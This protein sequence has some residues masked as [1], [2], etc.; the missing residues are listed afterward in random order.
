MEAGRTA[1]F[2]CLWCGRSWQARS[3]GDLEAW[4][5]LC[6]D[7]LGRAGENAFLR[8]RLK[9][10]LVERAAAAG[11]EAGEG[12]GAALSSHEGGGQEPGAHADEAAARTGA[13]GD[14]SAVLEDWYLRR[15]PFAGGPLQD[16]A[17]QA[18]LDAAGRWLEGLALGPRIVE[19]ADGT[20][21]WSPLLSSVAELWT[22]A[23]RPADLE[24]TRERLLAH[25]LRAHLHVRD[26]W[27]EPAPPA[28]PAD[29]LFA[30][31][32][33]GRL[34]A[35]R[36]PAFAALARRWLRADG[37]LA[38][39]EVGSIAGPVAPDAGAARAPAGLPTPLDGAALR[40]ALAQAAFR[41]VDIT[42]PGRSL[43]LVRATA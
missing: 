5:R 14:P 40:E 7:C 23:G 41:A 37:T 24:R 9:R 35:D 38:L 28:A 43:L 15:G 19:F 26:A 12:A 42:A 39:V 18:E 16:V 31:F 3:A 11:T 25:G 2:D 32:A 10:A 34:P 4:A 21:W 33:F 13:D 17:W 22:F 29:A 8:F 20:G 36:W 1:A 27:A 6:P 30:A